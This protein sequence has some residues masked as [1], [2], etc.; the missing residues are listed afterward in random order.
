M[1]FVLNLRLAADTAFIAVWPLSRVLLM[2][3][4][5]FPW[6]I[7]VP[8]CAGV[9]EL[10][11]L[12]DSTRAMLME[13]IARASE[14]LKEWALARAGGDKINIGIIGNIVAQLHVHIVARA[15]GDSAWPGT[16]WGTGKAVPYAPSDLQRM[17]TEFRDT[18]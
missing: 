6:I 10:F 13:E 2:N 3:D 14:R 11:E 12:D 15:R 1:S 17:I 4:S 18:L 9:A 16:V 7:L 5:R 8:R